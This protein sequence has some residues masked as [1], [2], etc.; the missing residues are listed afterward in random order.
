MLVVCETPKLHMLKG[1]RAFAILYSTGAYGF[2]EP[3]MD[4]NAKCPRDG[5]R[6][7]PWTNRSRK[8]ESQ[9]QKFT[10]ILIFD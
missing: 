10:L 3:F 4:Y 6:W 7:I 2:E 5:K 9:K 1:R 8:S